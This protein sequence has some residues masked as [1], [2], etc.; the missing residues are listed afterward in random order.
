MPLSDA[1]DCKSQDALQVARPTHMPSGIVAPD[2]I[3][4]GQNRTAVSALKGQADIAINDQ[5][6]C[7]PKR[8]WE[9]YACEWAGRP[10]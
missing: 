2:D 3:S 7:D 6:V 1:E 4:L 5:N 8:T 9:L 10:L